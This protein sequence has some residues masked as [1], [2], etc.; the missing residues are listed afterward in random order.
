MEMAARVV[1]DRSFGHGTEKTPNLRPFQKR[2][3]SATRLQPR[4]IVLNAG[5]Q[6]FTS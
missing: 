4:P 2:E 5:P 6:S 1:P 3:G